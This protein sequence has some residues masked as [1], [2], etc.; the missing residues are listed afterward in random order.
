MKNS[1]YVN[2]LL[3]FPQKKEDKYEV[4]EKSNK[5]PTL[6]IEKNLKC[7]S[8]NTTLVREL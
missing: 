1:H 3:S 6:I 4:G 2:V 8:K 7:R 5:M